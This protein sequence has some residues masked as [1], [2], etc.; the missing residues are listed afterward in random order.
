MDL[1]RTVSFYVD[2]AEGAGRTEVLAF[3]ATD[4]AF[5]VNSRHEDRSSVSRRVFHH[6]NGILGTMF[7]T[8]PTMVTVGHGDAVLLNPHSVTDMNEGFIFL[9]DSLNSTRRAYLRTMRT[10]RSAITALERHLGLHEA[11]RVRRRTQDVVR[12]RTH[13]QLT[14]RT[15]TLH[16]P[17]RDS[18]RRYYRRFTMRS[19]LIFY[20][21]QTSIDFDL[22]LCESRRSYCNCR[23][24]QKC[25]SVRRSR[26]VSQR[27]SVSGAVCQL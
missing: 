9:F 26:S 21:C 7:G 23:A 19:Y 4:T 15:M 1:V 14:R 5:F 17:C 8:R 11:E 27:R 13:A 6:L 25:P 2:C 10:L 22:R 20:L 3:T 12:T 18:P 24:S 16:V